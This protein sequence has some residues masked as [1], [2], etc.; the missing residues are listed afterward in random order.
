[1]PFEHQLHPIGSGRR[2]PQPSICLRDGA[3]HDVFKQVDCRPGCTERETGLASGLDFVACGKEVIQGLE[4][5]LRVGRNARRQPA[6]SV[7]P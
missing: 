5:G 6:P 7:V 1:M 4:V 3:D 2:R